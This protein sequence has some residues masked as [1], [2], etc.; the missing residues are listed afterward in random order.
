MKH[1]YNASN[2]Y[3]QF[4]QCNIRHEYPNLNYNLQ[5]V[6]CIILVTPDDTQINILSINSGDN[7]A[8]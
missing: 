1:K 3:T 5:I 7:K 6:E 8:N 2:Y 4:L